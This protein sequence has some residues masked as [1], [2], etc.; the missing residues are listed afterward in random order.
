MNTR[1]QEFKIRRQLKKQGLSLVKSRIRNKTFD[2]NGGYMI[3][4]TKNNFVVSGQ[5]FDL[6][7]N[8]VE[9][10]LLNLT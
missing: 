5:R 2:N 8:D 10:Y 4:D 1:N 3:V 9:N 6:E 7:L